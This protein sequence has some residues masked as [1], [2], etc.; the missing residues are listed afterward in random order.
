[1]SLSLCVCDMWWWTLNESRPCFRTGQ[2]RRGRFVIRSAVASVCLSVFLPSIK[3]RWKFQHGHGV[4]GTEPAAN[5][6]SCQAACNMSHYIH[7][8]HTVPKYI[9]TLGMYLST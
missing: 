4:Y 1:M 2:G 5:Q 7:T 9:T 8:V 3:Q 6:I